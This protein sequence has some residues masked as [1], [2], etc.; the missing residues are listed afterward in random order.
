MAQS[1]PDWRRAFVLHLQS[2]E[3]FLIERRL[4]GLSGENAVYLAGMIARELDPEY[5]ALADAYV[6]RNPDELDAV[7]RRHRPCLGQN[8]PVLMVSRATGERQAMELA[9]QRVRLSSATAQTIRCFFVAAE[10]SHHA[11][12]NQLARIFEFF[13][14]RLPFV[15]D[16]VNAYIHELERGGWRRFDKPDAALLKRLAASRNESNR[17]KDFWEAARISHR[18]RNRIALYEFRR[19]VDFERPN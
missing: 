2:L 13:G 16:V 10:F 9:L 19:M 1:A 5:R 6:L 3:L 17:R 4:S 7:V 14:Y 18:R 12:K 8:A 11:G 15:L